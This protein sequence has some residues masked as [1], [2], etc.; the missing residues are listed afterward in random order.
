MCG[1][2]CTFW[3][4]G[5]ELRDTDWYEATAAGGPVVMR[6]RA[7]FPYQMILI[8]G[9]ECNN[10]QYEYTT[11]PACTDAELSHGM[12]PG[13]L[14]WLWHSS[15]TFSGVPWSRYVFTVCGIGD[16]PLPITRMTWGGLKDRYRGESG[17]RR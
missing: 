11:A 14:V 8:Y 3:Y 6:G 7:E 5:M 17:V 9:T 12:D 10:L 4:E 16:N 13:E 2:S 15:S 1:R